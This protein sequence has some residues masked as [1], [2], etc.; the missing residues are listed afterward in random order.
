MNKRIQKKILSNPGHRRFGSVSKACHDKMREYGKAECR[1]MGLD[2]NRWGSHALKW[3]HRLVRW[4]K[5]LR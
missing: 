5:W 2:P 3:P 4:A 1:R